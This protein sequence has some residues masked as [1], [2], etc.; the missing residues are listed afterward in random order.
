MV[1][2]ITGISGAGKSTIAT[3]LVDR[4][5]KVLPNLINIDGDAIRNLYG[6]DLGYEEAHR[7]IQIKRLQKLCL[8]LENQNQIII[9]S[10]LYSNPSL[11]KWNRENFSDYCEIYLN[12]SIELVKKRDPKGIYKKYEI[13]KE[14]NIVGIDVPWHEPEKSNLVINIDEKKSVNNITDLISKNVLLFKNT[15]IIQSEN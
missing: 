11:M 13:G 10:A 9:A 14:K 2:W 3:A 5:K 1:I 8:F 15:K 4:Y 12:I 7:I 6:N